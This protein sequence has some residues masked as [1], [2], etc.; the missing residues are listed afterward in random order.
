MIKYIRQVFKLILA[1]HCHPSEFFVKLSVFL[2]EFTTTEVFSN[3]T[4]NITFERVEAPLRGLQAFWHDLG[5]EVIH[6]R[7]TADI[8]LEE[9]LL[10]SKEKNEK[11]KRRKKFNGEK[12]TRNDCS[13]QLRQHHP[14]ST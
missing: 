4:H 13:M 8:K 5:Y 7:H 6:I 3:S 11:R 10:K 1:L 9:I 12:K 2:D 14:I